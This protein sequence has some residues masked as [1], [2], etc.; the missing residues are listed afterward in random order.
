[1]KYSSAPLS[2][3]GEPVEGNLRP[4]FSQKLLLGFIQTLVKSEETIKLAQNL[5]ATRAKI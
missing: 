1:M 4:T 5:T 3:L 2:G